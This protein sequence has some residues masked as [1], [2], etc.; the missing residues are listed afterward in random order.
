MASA[1]PGQARSLTCMDFAA[2]FL[3][4]NQ[5]FGA[6]IAAGDPATEV[7]TCP[8]WTLQQLFRHVGRG[9]RWAAQMVADRA[10]E[11]LDPRTVRG[12]KPPVGQ[13]LEWL[14]EG[15]RLLVSAADDAADTEVWTFLGPR[16]ASWWVRRRLHEVLVHG[17]DAAL[18]LGQPVALEPDLAAD[19]V[20]EFL[21][22]VTQFDAARN[23]LQDGQSVH[24]HAVDAAGEWTLA[25]H[26]DTVSWS[27][28]HGKGTVALRGTAT[29]LLLALT[30]RRPRAETDLQ[31]FGDDTVWQSWVD[32]V[33]F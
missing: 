13:E 1:L 31:T 17:V 8:G 5:A 11:N 24:L 10:T 26:G 19:A 22:I 23:A 29:D 3:A 33:T 25:R 27:E 20:S 30:R 9:N 15:G 2:E 16:P 14:D 6:L 12:G 7:P 32:H 28:E 4:E 18:A 21:D